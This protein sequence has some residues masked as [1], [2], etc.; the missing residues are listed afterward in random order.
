M[1]IIVVPI[2]VNGPGF[3]N[4]KIILIFYNAKVKYKKRVRTIENDV[5]FA[6]G[7]WDDGADSGER[8]KSEDN[9]IRYLRLC[10]NN[11]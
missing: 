4:L 11:V 5:L 1:Y 9:D 2:N 7:Q 3:Q 6:G 8:C 10:V